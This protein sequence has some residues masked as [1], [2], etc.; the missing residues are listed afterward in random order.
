[1]LL[2]NLGS[3][4]SGNC[5]LIKENNHAILVDCGFSQAYTLQE[6][7]KLNLNFS[8]LNG[9]L[10]TH[11]HTDHINK[12]ALK[13]FVDNRVPIFCHKRVADIIIKKHDFIKESG[14]T[15]IISTFEDNIFK[16]GPLSVQAFTVPHDSEG[17]CVGYNIYA[18]NNG[19]TKKITISTDLGYT[20][21]GLSDKFKDSDAIVIESNHD[22]GMLESSNRPYFLIQRIKEIG[23]LSNNQCSKFMLDV[24]IKSEKKPSHIMLAHISQQCNTNGLAV[25]SMR[26]SL[27]D[28]KYNDIEIVETFKDK[29]SK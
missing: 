14:R 18:V 7:K 21:D 20:E 28:N 16:I 8:L 15:N 24:L 25:K 6:L 4:S 23:H 2:Q 13:A 12:W 19:G 22:D 3:S 9:V 10:I 26:K 27:D 1:M 17:G 29:S 11:T 5:T